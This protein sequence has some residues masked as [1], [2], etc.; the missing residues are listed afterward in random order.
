MDKFITVC[1][2]K[3][4]SWNLADLIV[5]W[6]TRRNNQKF[7]NVPAHCSIVVEINNQQVL[8]E[9]IA[10]G[11]NS[12][13]ATTEDLKWSR[14]INVP[15]LQNGINFALS[16][17]NNK[18]DWFTIFVIA[19]ARIFPDRWFKGARTRYKHICAWFVEQFLLSSGWIENLS[20]VKQYL[21]ISPNDIW[22]ED[23]E[24]LALKSILS[25]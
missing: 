1:F 9:F 2:Y 7:S 21:P 14:R 23:I 19:L 5:R 6:D 13:L 10:T 25:L 4:S 11:W 20:L 16:Q 15:N 8:Y 18:Y 22:V 12:R 3:G 17:K 24:N